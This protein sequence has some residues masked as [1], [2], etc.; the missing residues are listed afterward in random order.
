M[1]EGLSAVEVGHEIAHHAKHSRHG[2]HRDR[3]ISIAEA[4]LLSVVT[5]AAAW[6]GY[7][8]AK[9]TTESSLELAKASATRAAANREF[10][11]ALIFRVDDATTFNAWFGAYVAGDRAGVR[12]AERRFR[13]GYRRAFDAWLATRP[14]TNPNAPAGPQAMPQYVPEG[15]AAARHLDDEATALYDH[16]EHAAETGDD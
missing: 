3:W 5:L 8:A 15:D 10:Q 13:P 7:S 16:G 2:D 12:V 14:F 11:Q 1:G 4:L 6:S 9:W